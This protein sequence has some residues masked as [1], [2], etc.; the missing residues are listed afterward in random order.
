M[1]GNTGVVRG[2]TY[3]WTLIE[4]CLEIAHAFGRARDSE[5]SLNVGLVLEV[6]STASDDDW[7]FAVTIVSNC[8][9]ASFALDPHAP[10]DG[11]YSPPH[12]KRSVGAAGRDL[13]RRIGK[14]TLKRYTK[15]SASVHCGRSCCCAMTE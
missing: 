14:R 13:H 9:S 5:D 1:A 15:H 4:D 11:Q 2:K 8:A 12:V 10:C 3:C 7:Y 6:C